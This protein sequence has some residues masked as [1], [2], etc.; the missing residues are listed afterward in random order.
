M[1]Q[2]TQT[3]SEVNRI[4]AGFGMP[5]YKVD[6]TWYESMYQTMPRLI[7]RM[8]KGGGPVL[9][10][11]DVV[12]L[13][14]HSSSDDQLKYRSDDE[15]KQAWARDPIVLTERYLL[16]NQILS[17][18]EMEAQRAAL[19]DEVDR[20]SD[21]ADAAAHP[22]TGRALE[23]IYSD[24]K[25][26]FAEETPAYVSEDTISMVE[27]INRGLREE[28]ERNPKIV[29]WGEDVADPKGGVFGVTKGLTGLYPERVQNAP[30]AEA[31]ILGV[32]GGMAI[33]GYKPVIEIQFADYIWPAFQQLRNEIPTLR[34]RSNGAWTNPMV[35]RPERRPH[36]GWSVSLLLPRSLVC[37][38]SGLVHRVSKQRG[39]RQGTAENSH[40]RR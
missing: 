6:G 14:S 21:E 35:V 10:E 24:S 18:P 30:L 8:R 4:A 3:A 39:G 9:V 27:A 19:K 12:R 36:Q 29:M 37:P 17:A 23:Q 32:A 40:S 11:A 20:A 15:M 7:E 25:P 31:S 5:S 38:H 22:A 33:G 16:E 28:M 34:W 2:N 13:E 1:P 26:F